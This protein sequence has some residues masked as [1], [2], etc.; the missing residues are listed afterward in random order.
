MLD[1]TWDE[2]TSGS[3]FVIDP[4]GKAYQVAD[5]PITL[6]KLEYDAEPGTRRAG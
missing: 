4:L 2:T 5:P 6:E 1:G 3:P